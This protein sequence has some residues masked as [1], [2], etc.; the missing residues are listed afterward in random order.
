MVLRRVVVC[1]VSCRFVCRA[2]MRLISWK[3]FLHLY[4]QAY[5]SYGKHGNE[6]LV[7]LYG[8]AILDNSEELYNLV[9]PLQ[10]HEHVCSI[11]IA[12]K[13]IG[14]YIHFIPL[15]SG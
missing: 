8:F 5:L 6:T 13:M 4:I 10:V 7:H 2:C 3:V 11:T 9:D 15:R 14:H 1:G 12:F